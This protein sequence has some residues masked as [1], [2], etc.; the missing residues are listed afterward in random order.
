MVF[1]S[2]K[3]GQMALY[4]VGIGTAGDEE[5]L[6]KSDVNL[7]PESFTPDGKTLI[8]VTTT[9]SRDVFALP[10]SGDRISIQITNTAFIEGF[11]KLSP[12][13]RWFAYVSNESGR[14]E[15]YAQSFP[16]NH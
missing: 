15:I 9:G 4:R 11:P 13:G 14:D 8:Y 1:R 12:D 7:F 10:L 2:D 3:G 6:M 16:V 5:L